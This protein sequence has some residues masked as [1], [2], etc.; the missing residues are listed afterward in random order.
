MIL[1]LIFASIETLC[2]LDNSTHIRNSGSNESVDNHNHSQNDKWDAQ[3]L[4]HVKEET[5]LKIDLTLLAE[6]DKEA[7]KEDAYHSATKEQTWA[8]T[9]E[10]E[11]LIQPEECCKDEYVAQR[12]VELCWVTRR[13]V[14]NRLNHAVLRA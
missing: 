12:L 10:V 3:H 6:L 4:A 9:A 14:G 2:I 11:T 13:H 5:I 8:T 1:L 7:R